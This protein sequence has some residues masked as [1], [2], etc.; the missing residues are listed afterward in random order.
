MVEQQSY[1]PSSGTVA[2]WSGIVLAGGVV[3]V[4][5]ATERSVGGVRSALAVAIVAVVVWCYLLRPRI[6][7]RPTT[8]LLRNAF[9]DWEIPLSS[10]QEVS[11]RTVT[12]VYTAERRYDG[13]AVGRTVRSILRSQA[14]GASDETA[15]L[16]T[17]QVTRAAATARERGEEAGPATRTRAYPEIVV[18]LAL[19]MA[20][21]ASLPF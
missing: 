12:G 15:D 20:L 3:A 11:V 2:G 17:R 4:L 6:V 16:V 9:A 19:V 13:I 8:L 1:G 10:I 21:L 18:L 5:L 7:V 14:G